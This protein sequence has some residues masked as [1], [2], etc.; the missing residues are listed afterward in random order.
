MFVTPS[1]VAKRYVSGHGR[2]D[3]SRECVSSALV[4]PFHAIM[5]EL[6]QQSSISTFVAVGISLIAFDPKPISQKNS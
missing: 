5:H 3:G 2:P 4:R 1:V 6:I